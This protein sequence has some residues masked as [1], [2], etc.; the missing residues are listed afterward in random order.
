MNIILSTAIC[1][2]RNILI[3]GNS[4]DRFYLIDAHK[5]GV[6]R[7]NRADDLAALDSPAPAFFRRTE[8]LRFFL[9]YLNHQRLTAADKALARRA[10]KRAEPLRDKQLD[11]VRRRR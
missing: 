2:W 10:L 3:S 4:L 5:G 8:R 7:G 1:F 9:R 6:R 11:R